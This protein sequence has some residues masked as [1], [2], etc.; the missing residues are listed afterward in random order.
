MRTLALT[1][2]A[3][4]GLSSAPVAADPGDHD[5]GFHHDTAEHSD[6]D[7]AVEHASQ[8]ARETADRESRERTDRDAAAAR[9]GL[10]HDGVRIDVAEGASVDGDIRPSEGR[11]DV[12]VR[13][14]TDRDRD[15]HPDQ[16]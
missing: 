5:F 11:I 7:R 14:D 13:V 16:L 2:F 9:E 6:F 15:P 8:D 12:N 10:D 3:V 4:A 1:A